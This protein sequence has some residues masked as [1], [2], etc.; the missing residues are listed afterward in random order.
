MTH[1]KKFAAAIL[2]TGIASASTGAQAQ[3]ALQNGASV[4]VS[5]TEQTLNGANTIDLGSAGTTGWVTT[6]PMS[7]SYGSTNLNISFGGNGAEAGVY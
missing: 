7:L 5:M 4:G 6:M 2:I 3:T 1:I